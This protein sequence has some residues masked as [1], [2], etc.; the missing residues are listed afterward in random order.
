MQQCHIQSAI[1]FRWGYKQ[2]CRFF[3]SKTTNVKC[4]NYSGYLEHMSKNVWQLFQQIKWEDILCSKAIILLFYA[5]KFWSY[6][7]LNEVSSTA[8]LVE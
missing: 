7:M 2:Q 3:L 5:D 6:F 4:I 1:S 8:H